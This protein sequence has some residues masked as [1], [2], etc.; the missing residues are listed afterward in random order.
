MHGHEDS[1]WSSDCL[2]YWWIGDIPYWYSVCLHR[3]N[4]AVG[5]VDEVRVLVGLSNRFRNSS[6]HYGPDSIHAEF[7]ADTCSSIL[8]LPTCGLWLPDP[9]AFVKL[10]THEAP[11]VLGAW[12]LCGIVAA[13]M[14]TADG[15]ILAM[16]VKLTASRSC[17]HI[18]VHIPIS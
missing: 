4:H 5:T 18:S 2:S 16:Y 9:I 13:S 15:A 12:C 17:T 6:V 3:S 1:E 11:T 14:S 7:A 8:G 10:L